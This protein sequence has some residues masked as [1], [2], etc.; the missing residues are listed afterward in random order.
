MRKEAAELSE[1]MKQPRRQ[2]AAPQVPFLLL[3]LMYLEELPS[4]RHE[5][6]ITT[7]STIW[8]GFLALGEIRSGK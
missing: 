3:P 4:L 5:V 1:E 2:K 7:C 6:S 8:P